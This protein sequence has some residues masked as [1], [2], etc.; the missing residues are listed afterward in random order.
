MRLSEISRKEIVD[1]NEGMFW[2]PV[3]KADVLID[4]NTGDIVSLLL[5]GNKGFIGLGPSEEI[6][7]PWSGV[8]KIGKDAIIVDIES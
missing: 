3:G 8:V 7:I 2:G 6:N 5:I 1:I 4:P